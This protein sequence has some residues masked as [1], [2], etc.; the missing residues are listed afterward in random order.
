MSK[1][2]GRNA[3]TR[4]ARQAQTTV[5]GVPG[6]TRSY[7]GALAHALDSKTELFQLACSNFVSETTFYESGS[8]RDKRFV[9]LID[10]VAH[11]DP[12][13]IAALIPWLRGEG[14]MRTASLVLAVELCE[15]I[16]AGETVTLW[17]GETRTR[18]EIIDS[19]MARADE[20]AEVVGYYMATRGR[21]LPKYLKRGV[22]DG[23]V[24]LYNERSVLKW[25][26]SGNRI[27]FGDVIDLTHPTPA[28]GPSVRAFN[29]RGDLQVSLEGWQGDLFKHLLDRRHNRPDFREVPPTL[30]MLS[31]AYRL[32]ALP[33]GQ[34]RAAA[35]PEAIKAAGFSW[36]RVAGW[37][38]GGMDAAAWEAVIPSM[39]YMA[40]M[41]NLR[42][43]ED[44]GVS[45][46]VLVEVA[47]K[48]SDPE[49]VA[50]SRQLP[51]RFWAAYKHS[52]TMF[53]GPALE[54]ATD[55]SLG[56]VPRL[57]GRTL[58]L[59]DTSASMQNPA[60]GAKSQ[61]KC[62]EAAALFGAALAASTEATAV[63]YADTWRTVRIG[64]SVLRTIDEIQS[65][66]GSVGHGTMTWPSAVEAFNQLGPFDRIVAF[67][68]EQNHPGRAER[69]EQVGF[70]RSSTGRY[71]SGI[72]RYE[73]GLTPA[74]A[75][76]KVP[77]YAWDLAGYG[78]SSQDLTEPNRYLL[79]GF[80]DQSFGQIP[81]L[82]A[83]YDTGWPWER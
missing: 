36:E 56:N 60:G 43:F 25:D 70:Y 75:L 72:F 80:T 61:I 39:S 20:P 47:E 46:R 64:R 53:F 58:V 55:L 19:C 37:I 71:Q 79:A 52:G 23:A 34:R 41:R 18:R 77:V 38:P 59:I 42:N 22:A 65:L 9:A 2:S 69:G 3:T 5:P 28:G 14:N 54:K 27:R 17:N 12:G 83:G 1:F 62:V 31:A 66:I 68:D 26:G 44:A 74:T 24:R 29:A 21:R 63:I 16:P 4:P 81:R 33:E 67:T 76:P 49:Q 35:T 15:R 32:D 6:M 45:T 48:L 78:N 10:E 11:D 57:R 7:E 40:L 73:H 82:E 13:W 51:F 8:D 30:P 50:R